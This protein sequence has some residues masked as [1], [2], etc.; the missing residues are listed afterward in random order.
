M[1]R[2]VSI[3]QSL[4]TNQLWVILLLS[5]AILTVTILGARHVVWTLSTELI[6]QTVE[7]TEG[8]LRTFFEPVKRALMVYRAMGEAGLLE[9]DRHEDLNRLLIPLMQQLS[10][11]TSLLVADERGHEHMLLRSGDRWFNRRTR[12]DEWGNRTRWFEWSDAH[13]ERIE[14]WKELDYEPRARP[15]YQGAINRS[16][17][18][19]AVFAPANSTEHIHWTRPYTFFTTHDL[20]ITASITYDSGDGMD[21]V[22]GFDLL[23]RDISDF[24]TGLKVGEHGGVMVLTDR[25]KVI[26]LP[27]DA[28]IT[29]PKARQ[30]ALL[31]CPQELGWALAGEAVKASSKQVSKQQEPRR[32]KSKGE[33]WWAHA[34]PYP[35]TSDRVLWVAVVIPESDLLGGLHRIRL[36][37]VVITLAVIALA[38]W[39]AIVLAR[40][41]S[42][43]IEALVRQSDRISRGNLY[44][45]A[46][47]ESS[48]KEVHH[49]AAAH[50]RM[51]RGLESLLKLESDLL[52]AH[53]I[54]QNT[55]PE[56]LPRVKG[57]QIDAWSTPA[58]KTGGDTYDIVGLQGPRA[59]GERLLAFE[60]AQYAVLL[61]ADATGH[62]V[63]PALSATQVRAMLRMAVRMGAKLEAIARHVNDQLVSDLHAGRFITAWL[64]EL[65]GDASTL[66]SFSA[67]QAPLLHYVAG[68]KSIYELAA[69]SPP[70]GLIEGAPIAIGAPFVM[71]PG[72]I[73]MVMSDGIYEYKNPSGQRFGVERVKEVITRHCDSS[74]SALNKAL[75]AAL[76]AFAQGKSAGDDCTVIIIKRI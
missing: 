24:T 60:N 41:Y 65:N 17:E 62:G 29:D 4:L 9:P 56:R 33:F 30:A 21:R 45:G 44:K 13:P 32:Y 42:Y 14:S 43:P 20:G 3:R 64:G 25:S 50:E 46:P 74:A 51:R 27:R 15:W 36:W 8:E 38:I 57:F 6:L 10:Q 5:V 31:K 63:G 47:V 49:L 22:I 34:K 61:L 2:Q 69:D 48:V 39:R 58:D 1:A 73:V 28:R 55:F 71:S 59:E 70:F 68:E 40:R 52:L 26:G 66:T 7:R 54:Q 75:R 19:P 72:D 18:S 76:A 11:V 67:G 37:I 16:E 35:L 12:R 23:L 53:Q